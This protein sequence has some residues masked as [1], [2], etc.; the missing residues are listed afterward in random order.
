MPSQLLE[1]PKARLKIDP[2]GETT[3]IAAAKEKGNPDH[4]AVNRGWGLWTQPGPLVLPAADATR[5]ATSLL[6]ALGHLRG[7][8]V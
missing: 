5:P 4:R 6:L 2:A 1:K 8:N 3:G 7:Q